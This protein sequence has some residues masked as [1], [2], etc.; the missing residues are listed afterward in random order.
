VVVLVKVAAVVNAGH[1]LQSQFRS[2]SMDYSNESSPCPVCLS[3][4]MQISKL[5]LMA[6]CFTWRRITP[7]GLAVKV[8]ARTQAMN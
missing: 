8:V 3:V 1:V 7:V 6:R 4:N 2:T 5:G